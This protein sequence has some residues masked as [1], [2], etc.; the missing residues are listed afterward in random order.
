MPGVEGRK[1]SKQIIRVELPLVFRAEMPWVAE[2]VSK[3]AMG[4]DGYLADRGLIALPADRYR[5]TV[6]TVRELKPLEY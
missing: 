6:D 2:F 3:R 4:E 1:G 5:H